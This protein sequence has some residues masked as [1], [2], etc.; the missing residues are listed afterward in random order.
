MQ[1]RFIAGGLHGRVP[2]AVRLYY[3]GLSAWLRLASHTAY[4]TLSV[5]RLR[6]LDV[7]ALAVGSRVRP[8]RVV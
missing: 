6:R 8:A 2:I 1:S 5:V 3:F 4:E 7:L